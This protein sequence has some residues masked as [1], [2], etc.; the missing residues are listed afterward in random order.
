[1]FYQPFRPKTK[2]KLTILVS[3]IQTF[4]HGQSNR[5]FLP[6]RRAPC[7]PTVPTLLQLL[8]CLGLFI[9]F[10]HYCSLIANRLSEHWNLCTVRVGSN[11]GGSYTCAV[12][13]VGHAH[14]YD[15]CS[16]AHCV[17]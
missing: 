10:V 3:E 13:I 2:L 4:S 9:Q 12:S 7:L 17:T 6:G 5:G 8:C 11:C 14:S 16:F 1:M 15:L